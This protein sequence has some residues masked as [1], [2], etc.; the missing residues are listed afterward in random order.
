[1]SKGFFTDKTSRPAERD[2]IAIIGKAWNKWDFLFHH[3]M[4][5]F[6]LKG[7]F[8]FYGINYGW[9]LRFNKSGRSVIALYPDKDCFT[10]Q[11]ILNKNQTESALAGDLDS[12][13]IKTIR[14]TE[15]VH[16]GKWIYLKID[17]DTEMKDILTLVDIRMKIK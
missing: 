9:A 3:L 15:P 14:N 4:T 2:I 10:V 11:I 6:H 13:M 12:N 1:M 16:E 5:E 7:E 8:R 17:T